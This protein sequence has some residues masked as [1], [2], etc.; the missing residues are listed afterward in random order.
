MK[1]LFILIILIISIIGCTNGIR[2]N[3]SQPIRPIPQKALSQ[4]IKSPAKEDKY[5]GKIATTNNILKTNIVIK[6]KSFHQPKKGAELLIEK[7]DKKEE[8]P[9]PNISSRIIDNQTPS[10]KKVK[11]N[12]MPFIVYYSFAIAIGILCFIYYKRFRT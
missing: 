9:K 8:K 3:K 2:P 7:I 6:S 10:E 12:I 4:Q 1:S 11:I 5:E